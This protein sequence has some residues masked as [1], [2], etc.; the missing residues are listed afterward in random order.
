M[1]NIVYYLHCLKYMAREAVEH[2]T[3]A[4][5]GSSAIGDRII[6]LSKEEIDE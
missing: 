4:A 6:N 5:G 1:S 3:L 2:M